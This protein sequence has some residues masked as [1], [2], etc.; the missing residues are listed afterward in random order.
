MAKKKRTPEQIEER[1]RA[2]EEYRKLW[3]YLDREWDKLEERAAREGR[4]LRVPRP[5]RP[6]AAGPRTD[7]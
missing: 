3:D 7:I 6:V 2:R 5:A 4:S 1:R